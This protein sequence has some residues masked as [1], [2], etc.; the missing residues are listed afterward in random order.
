M[1]RDDKEKKIIK[2][3]NKISNKLK[4]TTGTF[5]SLV[6]MLCHH[7]SMHILKVNSLFAFF[8]CLLTNC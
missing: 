1:K 5:P 7:D 6:K 3:K 2:N 8:T 4:E